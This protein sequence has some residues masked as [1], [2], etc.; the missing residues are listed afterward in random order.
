MMAMQQLRSSLVAADSDR[1]FL[2]V[3]SFLSHSLFLS[4]LLFPSRKSSSERGADLREQL[5]IEAGSPLALTSWRPHLEHP[6]EPFE[7]WMSRQSELNYLPAN[8]MPTGTLADFKP[9]AFLRD[10][11]PESLLVHWA[12]RRCD[13]KQLAEAVRHLEQQTQKWLKTHQPW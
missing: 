10:L 7:D 4:Q 11:D 8:V 1:V 13:L 12:G 3:H 5:H 2:F 9:D 6:D